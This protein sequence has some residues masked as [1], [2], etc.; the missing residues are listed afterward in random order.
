MRQEI[1]PTR[2][3]T[4][5]ITEMA[6]VKAEVKE[7]DQTGTRRRLVTI[8]ARKVTS[9]P[10]AG[11]RVAEKKVKDRVRKATATAKVEMK[12]MLLMVCLWELSRTSH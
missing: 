2:T 3:R 7:K 1:V 9:G 4:T 6:K 8:A 5:K 12:I 11:R 10:T